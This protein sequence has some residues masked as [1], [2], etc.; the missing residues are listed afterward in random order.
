MSELRAQ[1]REWQAAVQKRLPPWWNR[2]L[3]A[4]PVLV[5]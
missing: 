2:A 5:V 4:V 1:L 3:A